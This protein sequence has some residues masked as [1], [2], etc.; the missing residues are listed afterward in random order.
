MVDDEGTSL[1]V[2]DRQADRKYYGCALR[3]LLLDE[4]RS[5]AL[6]GVEKC[7]GT[8]LAVGGAEAVHLFGH[9]IR[10]GAPRQRESP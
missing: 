1:G 8:G 10:A 9:R 5:S 7:A 6:S 3:A 2:E 4:P